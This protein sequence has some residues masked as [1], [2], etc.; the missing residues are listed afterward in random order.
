MEITNEKIK[1]YTF[2]IEMGIYTLIIG[3]CVVAIVGIVL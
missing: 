1:K 2:N 3:L